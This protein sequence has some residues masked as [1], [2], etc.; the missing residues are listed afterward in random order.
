MHSS[1]AITELTTIR[2]WVRWA[3]TEFERAQLFYG[4]GT[5]NAWDEAAA[6]VLWVVKTPWNKLGYVL[7]AKLTTAERTATLELI[8]KRMTTRKPTPYLTGEAHF[9]GLVF[10]VNESVLVPR[11]PIAEVIAHEF[12]PWIE[13][14]PKRILDLCTGSGCI[15]IACAI[16][17]DDAQVDL[18]DIS[19][20]A[21]ALARRNIAKHGLESRVRALE[22]DLFAQIPDTYDLIVSNP[23]YVD[24][25]D[26]ASLPAEYRA[27]PKLALQSGNDGLDFTRR[28]LGEASKHL[29]P[30]GLL[31]VEVGNSWLALENAYPNIPFS[32]L[33]FENGGHGVFALTR[34]QLD[35]YQNE[36]S[37]DYVG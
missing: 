16:T 18:S 34:E 19:A 22:S 14:P 27:E 24:A 12:L 30:G 15:G 29:A 8:E 7:D 20:D 32:W 1:T 9:A 25:E 13:Q 3:A 6:I 5:D 2:D 26:M 36:L 35:L 31:V 37:K 10:E 11:S 23:P 4:H 17:F 28:L 33:E 21:V